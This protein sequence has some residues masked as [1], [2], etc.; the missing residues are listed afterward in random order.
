MTM[1]MKKFFLLMFF[2][3]PCS[4][5]LLAQDNAY[6]SLVSYVYNIQAFN[7]MCQQEK[8]YLHFDNT[9]YFPGETI[10]FS[11]SVVNATT[12]LPAQS[13]VLYVELISPNG[14]LLKQLKLKVIDG[15]A[16]G[17]IPLVDA[18]IEEARA[19]RGVMA[20]PSGFYEVRAY[21]RTMLNFDAAGVFSR[22]FPVY[23]TPKKEGDY[24]K[25]KINDG[26]T[27]IDQ[28][29]PLLEKQKKVNLSFYPEGGELVQGVPNRVAFKAIG[30]DGIGIPVVGV[31]K[32]EAEDAEELALLSTIHD[33][34]GYF[35]FVPTKRRNTVVITYEGER[36]TFRL[37]DAVNKGYVLQ[38]DNLHPEYV[39][40]RLQATSDMPEELVG[41]MLMHKGNVV[42]V[43][44]ASVQHSILEFSILKTDFATGVHQL[45]LFNA[46]GEILGQR[47]L[48]INNGFDTGGVKVTTSVE[49]LA[50]FALVRMQLQAHRADGSPLSTPL[51]LSVRD[52][53]ELG[54]A[55]TDNVLTN[56]LL[57]SE[58][59]G[60]IYQP[61]FYFESNDRFHLQ[62][63]DLLM[64]IQGWTRYNWKQMAR[65]EPF[66]I[67]HYVEDGLVLDGYL[68]EFRRDKPMAGT[69]VS[70]SLYSPD[71]QYKQESTVVTDENGSFGFAVQEFAGKWDLFL[72]A[73]DEKGN[74]VNAR[75]CLDRASRPE[76]RAY[77]PLET[78]L[79]ESVVD[80]NSNQSERMTA[81]EQ[82][83]Q[84]DPDSVFLLD[85][86]DVHGRRKYI[87]YMTFKAFDAHEDTE[88]V[89][90][91]GKFTSKV[92]DYLADKG[93]N[94]DATRYD[95]VIPTGVTTR[96][97]LIIWS[98]EQCL[99]NNR[100]VLWYLHDEHRN[101]ATT[102]YTPGFDM[103]MEDVKSIIVYDSP[104]DYFSMPVVRESLP[105]EIFDSLGSTKDLGDGT[106]L[107]RG[108]YVV[109]IM[110]YPPG[111][112]RSRVKGK[113]QTTFRGYSDV[114]EFYA[115]EYPNGPIQGDVDYRRT[116][117]WNPRLQ[118]D[119]EGKAAV[120]FYNNGFSTSLKVSAEGISSDGTIILYK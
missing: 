52:G 90:D 107:G 70:M 40:G 22:V 38:V 119:E 83:L 16:H 47:M 41:I 45:T 63:L 12:H 4:S 105:P 39:T 24:N 85:N 27:A 7:N 34:M 75:M 82:A 104:F 100:R 21:T 50:P 101:L 79:P 68:M 109:D 56:M 92:R 115:P 11:A 25:L 60:Y 66:Y 80:D 33:G 74:D 55:N 84:E 91:R 10:W 88:F 53:Q 58:L 26:G 59:K 5:L 110:M 72:S 118:T 117:Y 73:K 95:G 67:H 42:Y 8:V 120:E 57:S 81:E 3:I 86:I 28:Q 17:A 96:D 93:Y 61:H 89:L 99:I 54:T 23:E 49:E 102:G 111:Q 14:V 29:R 43:D 97:D 62:A 103:D 76:L 35:T 94:V 112:R 77:T 87:D 30:K 2:Y 46:K 9:A 48:F 116:L 44:T 36:Y 98:L 32:G 15:H 19:L 78:C 71:R 114:Q 69:K 20:L 1:K 108:L 64:M 51:S 37:P 65:V 31:V 6:R 18:S 113:R 106:I 13:K